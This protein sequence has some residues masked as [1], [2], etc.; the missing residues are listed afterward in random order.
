ME[1]FDP[2]QDINMTIQS[3]YSWTKTQQVT[4]TS[5]Y[6]ADGFE[7]SYFQIRGRYYDWY[8]QLYINQSYSGNTRSY[9]IGNI[10]ED[11]SKNYAFQLQRNNKI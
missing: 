3:G 4:G 6:L 5:R 7:Y 9:N 10:I 11:H 2:K 1:T 8:S